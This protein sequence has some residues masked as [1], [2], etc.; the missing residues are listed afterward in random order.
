[1]SKTSTSIVMLLLLAFLTSFLAGFSRSEY[2]R[3]SDEWYRSEEGRRAADNILSWQSIHGSWPKNLDTKARPFL[4]DPNTLKGTFDNSA[5]TGELRFLARAFLATKDPRYQQAF[6]KGLD[7]IL[8]AQY[9]TGGWPQSYPP[10]KG[11]HRYITFNDE[12]MVLLM[13]LL[14]DVATS[15][16]YAFVDANRRKAAQLSFDRGIECILKCQIV[17]N[18]K[19]TVWCAQHDEVDYSP[20]PARSYELVSLSGYESVGILRL[21]MSIDNPSP[22][23]IRAVKAGADWFERSKLTGIRQVKI[24]GDKVIIEDPNAPP[25]WARFYEIDTNRP[26]FCGRDGVKKYKLSEIEFERR[27]DYA[28]YGQWWQQFAAEDYALWKE[29]W[30]DRAAGSKIATSS[31]SK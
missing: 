7:H 5:T 29:K 15:K 23:I 24:N 21:L 4:G 11:Y 16:D 17:I 18:G 10:G 28:W 19:L 25:L 9:P 2:S 1:M 22:E 6:L 14:R 27:D 3:K 31:Q 8:E 26:F 30:L 12:T 13:R 20:R